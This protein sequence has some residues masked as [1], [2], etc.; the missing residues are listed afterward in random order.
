MTP[1]IF[2]FAVKQVSGSFYVGQYNGGF[3]SSNISGFT[4][5]Y[6]DYIFVQVPKNVVNGIGVNRPSGDSG[7]V[8]LID[9]LSVKPITPATIWRLRRIYYPSNLEID[10]YKN[11]RFT[12]IGL[13]YYRDA[14]N[15]ILGVI[16]G[17]TSGG[18][19]SAVVK[20]VAGT[21]SLVNSSW[22]GNTLL[23]GQTYGL[24]PSEDLQEWTTKVDDVVKQDALSITDFDASGTWYAGLCVLYNPGNEDELSIDN[25][26]AE[27]IEGSLPF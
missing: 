10:V 19:Y 15:Y 2:R 21:I 11:N 27:R 22:I 13:G 7:E 12:V 1:R 4:S 18:Y 5:D 26:L 6:A 23:S 17:Q 20:N 24:Y 3:Y 14:D 9:N 25:F 8:L 16:N